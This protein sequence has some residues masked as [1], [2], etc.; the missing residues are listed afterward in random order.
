MQRAF[1]KISDGRPTIR[2][3]KVMD[4]LEECKFKGLKEENV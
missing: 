1:K 2:G 3:K 4:C